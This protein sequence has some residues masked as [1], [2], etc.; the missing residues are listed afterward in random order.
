MKLGKRFLVSVML[1]MLLGG[2]WDRREVNDVAFV[3]ASAADKEGDGY[4]VGVQIP[5]PGQMGGPEGGGGGTSGE[6][7]WYL[8][9]EQ[10]KTL[11]GALEKLQQRLSRVL[12]FS[13]R[14]VIVLG[15]ELAKEGIVSVID[16]LIRAP[17]NR[18]TV[19]PVIAEGKAL[20]LLNAKAPVEQLPSEVIRELASLS[21]SKQLLL[22]IFM[23]DLLKEGEDP[24]LPVM[25]MA[26]TKPGSEGKKDKTIQMTGLGVMKK[27]RL[28]SIFREEDA[29]YLLW[30]NQMNRLPSITLDYPEKKGY[31]VLQFQQNK[32]DVRP[33]IQ[34]D[35]VSFRIK[36]M[37]KGSVMEDTTAKNISTGIANRQLEKDAEEHVREAMKGVVSQLKKLKADPIGLGSRVRDRNYTFWRKHKKDWFELYSTADVYFEIDFN[38]EHTG[39]VSNSI[40]RKHVE[41]NS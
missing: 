40:I 7:S 8:D 11:R 31:I 22:N 20:D 25:K 18:L 41:V 15:E 26:E 32:V 21:F 17:Q 37:A 29:K 6:K 36:I 34:G 4:R 38:I 24:V 33:V 16:I 27:D 12:N 30:L 28:V 5:L 14:R 23:K 19:F 39:T 3:A 35:E 1:L 10:D 2:C 9:S 13:H